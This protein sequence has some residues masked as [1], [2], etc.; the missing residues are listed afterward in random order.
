MTG[1]DLSQLASM[2]P[3]AMPNQHLAVGNRVL[4]RLKKHPQL[5]HWGVIEHIEDRLTGERQRSL[6]FARDSGE[7]LIFTQLDSLTGYNCWVPQDILYS[8]E[9]VNSYLG[10]GTVSPPTI[11]RIQAHSQVQEVQEGEP[12]VEEDPNLAALSARFSALM[13]KGSER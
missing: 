12:V 11:S 3:R 8:Q 1:Y 4:V 9:W 2:L 13:D 6:D 10:Q 7:W 5:I